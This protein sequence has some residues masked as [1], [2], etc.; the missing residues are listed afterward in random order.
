[1]TLLDY[2]VIPDAIASVE[3]I[4]GL[5]LGSINLIQEDF[6]SFDSDIKYD[7]VCSF[8]FVEHFEDTEPVLRRHCHLVKPGGRLLITMPN[9][10]G[11]NGLLHKWF[12][13][14]NYNKHNLK[15]MDLNRLE[16]ICCGMVSRITMCHTLAG[17]DCGWRRL[18]KEAALFGHCFPGLKKIVWKVS[19]KENR[20]F[21]PWVVIVGTK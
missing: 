11:L 4:N 16:N 9:F 7:I 1:M 18:P 17:Q 8:G 13:P 14:E 2:V 15:A 6:F 10:L 3:S 21:S 19:V 12:D 20:F 5:P